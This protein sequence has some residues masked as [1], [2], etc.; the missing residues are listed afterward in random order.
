MALRHGFRSRDYHLHRTLIAH[1]SHRKKNVSM[2]E[3]LNAK[4]SL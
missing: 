3:K 2:A 4:D 1:E